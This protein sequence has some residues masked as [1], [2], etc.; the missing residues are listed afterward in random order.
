MKACLDLRKMAFD[1]PYVAENKA[2]LP[3]QRLYKWLA[4]R[5]TDLDGAPVDTDLD[6]MPPF[7]QVWDVTPCPSLPSP[8]CPNE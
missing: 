6:D 1:E 8:S 7:P 2:K 5:F 4:T 3:L